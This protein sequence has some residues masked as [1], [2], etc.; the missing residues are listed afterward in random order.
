MCEVAAI[1]FRA[2]HPAGC[3]PDFSRDTARRGEVASAVRAES[4]RRNRNMHFF[5]DFRREESY[6]WITLR[7]S[8][9]KI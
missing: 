1:H 6:I 7:F 9:R 2:A 4:G 5:L 3:I 8:N